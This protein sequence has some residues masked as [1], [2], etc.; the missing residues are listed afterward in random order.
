MIYLPLFVANRMEVHTD[1]Q[2]D[3]V[4]VAVELGDLLVYHILHDS[5]RAGEELELATCRVSN[6]FILVEKIWVSVVVS[7]ASKVW[8]RKV[9]VF[10]MVSRL[11][12]YHCQI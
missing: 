8:F 6:S 3:S 2:G 7:S 4:L 9:S 1:G 5:A 10:H 12:T 11:Q